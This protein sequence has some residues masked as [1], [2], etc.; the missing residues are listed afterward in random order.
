MQDSQNKVLTV[1]KSLPN[2]FRNGI[3]IADGAHRNGW[4]GKRCKPKCYTSLVWCL[5]GTQGNWLSGLVEMEIIH[6]EASITFS[7]RVS[8]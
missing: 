1:L 3:Q 5:K 6:P 8:Y 7:L 4:K 2:P